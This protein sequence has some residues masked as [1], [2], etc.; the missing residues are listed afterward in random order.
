MTD[1]RV[2]NLGDSYRRVLTYANTGCKIPIQTY[3][4]HIM[5]ALKAKNDSKIKSLTV[6]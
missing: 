4:S 3:L 6:K 1:Q 2:D 5:Q